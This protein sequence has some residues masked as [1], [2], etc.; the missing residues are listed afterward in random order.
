MGFSHEQIKLSIMM[1]GGGGNW[2]GQAYFR[3]A[4]NDYFSFWCPRIVM[5]CNTV[6]CIIIKVHSVK[7]ELPKSSIVYKINWRKQIFNLAKWP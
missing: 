3:D 4:V 1:G 6:L 7:S 5:Y 2:N